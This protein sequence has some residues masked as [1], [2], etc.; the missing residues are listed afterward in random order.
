LGKFQNVYQQCGNSHA[1]GQYLASNC[2]LP[3]WIQNLPSVVDRPNNVANNNQCEYPNRHDQRGDFPK[4]LAETTAS[5]ADGEAK[6]KTS[7]E[8]GLE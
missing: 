5:S 7:M 3:V 8:E 4:D 1:S 6:P 2:N